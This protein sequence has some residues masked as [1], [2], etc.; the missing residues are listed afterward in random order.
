M[1][2]IEGEMTRRVRT[3]MGSN[4]AFSFCPDLPLEGVSFFSDRK[5]L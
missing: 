3:T 4:L 2:V 1:T 5:L